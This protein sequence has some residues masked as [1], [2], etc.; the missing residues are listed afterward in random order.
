MPDDKEIL[1]KTI[2]FRA[3]EKIYK[4]L[5]TYLKQ[6]GDSISSV[7]RIA[8]HDYLKL[9]KMIKENGYEDSEEI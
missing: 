8:T 3:T 7:M 2:N 1:N 6:T 9:K 5:M 4:A